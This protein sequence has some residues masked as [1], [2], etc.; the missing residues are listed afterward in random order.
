MF[1]RPCFRTKNGKRRAYWA[2]VESYRTERGPRQRTVAYLGQLDEAGR[3]GVKRAAAGRNGCGNSRPNEQ[4]LQLWEDA[5][6]A[7]EW[8]EVDTAAVRVENQLVFGGPWLALQ[9]FRKLQLDDFFHQTIPKG[10][11]DVPWSVMVQILVICRLCNPSSELHIAEHYYRSTAMHELLG[12]AAE[13]VYDE[14]LYRAL[15]KLLPHK[16]ALETYLKHRL[17]ELFNLEYDLLLY[18]VT[19]TYFEGEANRNPMAQRGYSRDKRS[20]C[21]QVCIGLVVSKCGMPLGYKVFNGNR[22][23]VTTLKEIVETME[24]HYGKADRIWIGDRGMMSKKNIEFLKSGNRRYIIGASKASLKQFE[25]ELLANDWQTIRDGLEVKLCPSPEDEDEVFILCR[26]N[27]RRKKEAAM[28]GRFEQRIENELRKIAASC[29]KRKWKKQVIDRRVGRVMANNSRAAGLFEVGVSEGLDGR[30]T[31]SWNKKDD[32]RD[33][34]QLSEGCY[35]LRSNV[36]D[37]SSEELWKAYIQLTE[38]E[39]AFR[40]H[41]SDLRIRPIWHQ[42]ED[43]VLAHI[44]VCFLAYVL[45]KALEQMV[46]AAGLGTEPRR[47]LEELNKI[48]MVDVVLPTRCGI[49]IRRRCVAKPTEH[50]AILLQ[51]MGLQIPRQIKL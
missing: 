15:D 42:R 46:H 48:N 43:R 12:V 25:K 49:D 30:T 31:I 17:G 11:E 35:L 8:V 13:K 6:P 10:N 40:I 5:S 9:V 7:P 39:A 45:W 51:R 19:S 21:K 44:L 32:W 18:D 33:W 38:A 36:V 26:S 28:H 37:W 20:D 3:L 50:Q 14:R 29:K 24:R 23:D 4:Q 16:E 2:L 1:I 22:T 47:V 34:A 41:K 27:D